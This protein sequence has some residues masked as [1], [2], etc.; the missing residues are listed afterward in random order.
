M[1]SV[2]CPYCRRSRGPLSPRAPGW[3]RHHIARRRQPRHVLGHGG[4]K[5]YPVC[6][7][8]ASA[9]ARPRQT[10]SAFGMEHCLR[11][12][13]VASTLIRDRKEEGLCEA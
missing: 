2:E 8:R 6:R 13:A 12:R 10:A 4:R 3:G 9:A 7:N 1:P 11:G 5:R